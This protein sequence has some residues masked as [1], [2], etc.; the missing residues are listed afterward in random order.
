MDIMPTCLEVAGRATSGLDGV[1]LRPTFANQ[2]ALR[3]TLFFEH[4]GNRAARQGDWKLV[5]E[6]GQPWELYHLAND[7]TEMHDLAAREPKR[8][9]KLRALYQ[10]WAAA[11]QVEPWAKV[12]ERIRGASRGGVVLPSQSNPLARRPDEVARAV[13][14]MNAE[15]KKRGLPAMKLNENK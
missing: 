7:P 9:A 2:P 15:R 12:Q 11:H 4:V 6:F 10:D 8:L 3:Q 1:S 14:A 5:A 13:N